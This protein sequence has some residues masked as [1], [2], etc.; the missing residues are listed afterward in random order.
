MT[1]A[2]G[3][4]R[5]VLFDLGG[6]LV[7]LSGVPAL[8]GWMN[9]KLSPEELFAVWLRSPAVRA[10]ER[11]QSTPEEFAEKLVEEIELPI[12]GQQFLRDFAGWP[13]GLLPGA[14]E[15]VQRVS[16]RYTRAT[17][18]NT[19]TLHWSRLMD[20]MKLADAFDQHFASHLTGKIK[21]DEDA[22]QQVVDE[23]K[24][25]PCAIFFLDDNR[26]NVEAAADIG[27]RAVHVKGV[28]GAERALL[29]AGVIAGSQ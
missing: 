8:L 18:S 19:N 5:V 7:E 16:P 22:F 24:C 10:F 11:G 3:P 27:I 28:E 9:N 15:L 1:T 20:E 26:L 14:L 6:V 25:E 17:L 13:R 2:P 23:L 21:P 12:T 4:I 29:E